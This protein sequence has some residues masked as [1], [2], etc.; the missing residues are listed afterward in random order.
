M[1][2]SDER[3]ILFFLTVL[4]VVALVVFLYYTWLVLGDLPDPT[5]PP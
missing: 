5:A 2:R 4:A 1:I 3:A